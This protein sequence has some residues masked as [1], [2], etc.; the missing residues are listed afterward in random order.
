MKQLTLFLLSIFFSNHLYS[1][2]NNTLTCD[3]VRYSK[4]EK[5]IGKEVFSFLLDDSIRKFS[6]ISFSSEPPGV[7]R[8]IGVSLEDGT[9]VLVFVRKVKYQKT[10]SGNFKWDINLFYKETIYGLEFSDYKKNIVLCRL[11]F[12]K[13]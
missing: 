1:Q 10:F 11:G 12:K 9:E 4:F 3:N 2:N 8:G 5:Y 6:Y 7:L 13:Q